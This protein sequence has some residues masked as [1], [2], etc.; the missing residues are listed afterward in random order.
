MYRVKRF[1][2]LTSTDDRRD[3]IRARNIGDSSA[4]DVLISSALPI[5]P[6]TMSGNK[7][8]KLASYTMPVYALAARKRLKGMNEEFD[9]AHPGELS[10]SEEYERRM[11]KSHIDTS[12]GY[13]AGIGGAVGGA[14]LHKAK[15]VSE[16]AD[17][18]ADKASKWVLKN[19]ANSHRYNAKVVP[20]VFGSGAAG[21]YAY[22]R[23]KRKQLGIND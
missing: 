15:K 5:I 9:K 23:W 1:S 10:E 2:G 16:A 19:E 20:I 3:N 21:L 13:L 22:D 8:L 12:I 17:K 18:A 11:P 4:T 7:S 6:A 14:E